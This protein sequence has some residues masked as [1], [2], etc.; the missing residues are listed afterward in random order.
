MKTVILAAGLVAL[1][2]ATVAYAQQLIVI[3][4]VRYRVGA[5]NSSLILRPED[6]H[7]TRKPGPALKQDEMLVRCDEFV[8][9]ALKAQ[10]WPNSGE[11][12]LVRDH[13]EPQRDDRTLVVYTQRHQGYR[14]LGTGGRVEIDSYGRVLFAGLTWEQE[15]LRNFRPMNA[16]MLEKRAAAA[17][18]Y[19]RVGA[20]YSQELMIDPL[21]DA[22]AQLR[23]YVIYQVRRNHRVEGWQ[24]MLN[25][26]TGKVLGSATTSMN[27]QSPRAG[28]S[29]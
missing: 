9:L 27:A 21:G 19:P 24:I 3:S 17:V 2:L 16:V 20:P 15:K 29:Q 10:G 4:G 7:P 18:P 26:E 5:V 22:P 6:D 8:A 25:A 13:L 1:S 23:D 12:R 11:G 28:R 14:I